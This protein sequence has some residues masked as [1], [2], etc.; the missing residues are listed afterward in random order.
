[1]RLGF[2]LSMVLAVFPSVASGG[3]IAVSSGAEVV[4]VR[5]NRFLRATAT[6]A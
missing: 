2:F 6:C 1:M 4:D 5:T 3:A